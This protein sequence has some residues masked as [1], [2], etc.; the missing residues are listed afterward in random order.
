MC[1]ATIHKR[2]NKE[3]VISQQSL[4]RLMPDAR[5]PIPNSLFARSPE[6]EFK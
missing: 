6:P 2:K 4:V 5:C 1:P 3:V